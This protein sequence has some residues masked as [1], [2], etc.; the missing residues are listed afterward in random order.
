M[1]VLRAGRNRAWLLMGMGLEDSKTL[2]EIEGGD[3][4]IV[5]TH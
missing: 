2:L 1:V 4:F 5:Q 3:S